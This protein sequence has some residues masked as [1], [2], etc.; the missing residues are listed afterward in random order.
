MFALAAL[1][2][3]GPTS[4]LAHQLSGSLA[5][6]AAMRRALSLVNGRSPLPM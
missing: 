6:F 5:M 4:R 2:R 3:A 1:R